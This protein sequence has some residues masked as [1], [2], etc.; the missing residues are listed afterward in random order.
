MEG[1]PSTPPAG[2]EPQPAPPSGIYTLLIFAVPALLIFMMLSQNKRQKKLESQLKTG[3][4]VI[5]QAGLIGKIVDMNA[6]SSRVKLEIAPG[7]SVQILKSAI[8]G[9]DAG[10]TPADAKAGD[11]KQGDKGDKKDAAKDKP[12]DK[13][14]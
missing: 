7:V 12:Q 4:R 9:V 11:A 3:D 13:K 8:Q 2:Q 1:Q 14:A 10:D 6:Q 5:T